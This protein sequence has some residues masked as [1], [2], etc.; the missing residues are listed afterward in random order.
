M[1]F[2]VSLVLCVAMAVY[3]VL[4]INR[5]IEL[6]GVEHMWMIMLLKDNT[7]I[8]LI[9]YT[10]LCAG[11]IIGVAQMAPEMVQK[12]LKLTLHLPY[13]Q[14]RMISLMLITGVV[15][16][17]LIFAIQS[18][19]IAIY[20]QTLIPGELVIRVMLTAMPWYFAGFMAYLFSAAICL[21][22]AWVRRSVLVLLG[23]SAV[24]VCYLQPAPEAYNGM[25]TL[26]LV[27]TV[28]LSLLVAGSVVRFKEGIQ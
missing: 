13:P 5:L 11:L 1:A 7:F 23:I 14:M 17:L 4:R 6:K 15:E 26:M 27:F 25:A 28:L 8:D 16:L 10:P 2:F 20:Y 19:M 21:E 22:G 3:V 12:R 18:A 9:K 24:I